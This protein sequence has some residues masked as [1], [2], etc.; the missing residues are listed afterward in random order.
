MD[1]FEYIIEQIN[2]QKE[3]HYFKTIGKSMLGQDIVIFHTG[4]FSGKQLLITGGIHAREYISTMLCLDILQNYHFGTG[5]YIAPL[6][7]PDGVRL[8]LDGLSFVNDQDTKSMLK[9]INKGEDFSLYKANAYA[10]DLNE[11]FDA[12]FG[13]GNKIKFLPSSNGFLGEKANS[14]EN[15]FL[16][17]YIKNKNISASISYHSKGEVVYYGFSKLSKKSLKN[18]KKLAKI[19]SKALKFKKIR[20]KNSFG[21]LSDY[22]SYRKNI[23]SV[24]VEI[25]S[26]KLSHPINF[27]YL[28]KIKIGHMEMIE[29]VINE[30]CVWQF[31]TYIT[32]IWLN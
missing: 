17:K 27:L 16:L 13:Q 28:D 23:P 32:T 4:K 14:Y 6:L 3:K 8:C 22:L 31:A 12:G 18:A 25:G 11:N 19:V 1:S 5:C 26:D 21:G 10:V 20:S 15:K 7:N 2:I 29:K 30:F 24:T 9:R